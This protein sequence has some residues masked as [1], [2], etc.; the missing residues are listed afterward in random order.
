ME[1]NEL[2]K[3]EAGLVKRVG[4]AISITD[5]LLLATTEPQLIPYRKGDK[6][7]FCTPDKRIVIDCLYDWVYPFINGIAIVQLE[8]TWKFID[9]KGNEITPPD[10]DDIS[11]FLESM[12]IHK[13]PDIDI[14]DNQIETVTSKY[15]KVYPY[16]ENFALVKLNEK[17]GFIDEHL[18]EV[19]AC[20]YDLAYSFIDGLAQVKINDKMGFINKHNIKYWDN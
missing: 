14:S 16:S 7:G 11:N 2:I 5:K 19:I 15:N 12:L 18:N 10:Y 6:W 9:K 20:E 17:Y 1:N 3:Y 13:Y 8:S 4:N